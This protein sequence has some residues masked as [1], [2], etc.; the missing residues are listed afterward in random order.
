MSSEQSLLDARLIKTTL[1]APPPRDWAGSTPRDWFY[2]S[3]R[4]K[5]VPFEA[6]SAHADREFRE[7]STLPEGVYSYCDIKEKVNAWIRATSEEELAAVI[8]TTPPGLAADE[9][10]GISY[11]FTPWQRLYMAWQFKLPFDIYAHAK[12]DIPQLHEMARYRA[13]ESKRQIPIEAMFTLSKGCA[14]D[15]VFVT[16]PTACGKTALV[17]GGAYMIVSADNWDSLIEE[18]TMKKRGVLLASR[19]GNLM[20]AR[21]IIVAAGGN[22]F[23]HFATTVRRLKPRLHGVHVH[24]WEGT[25]KRFSVGDALLLDAIVFWVVPMKKLNE[26]LR[27]H[28][29]IAVA[30]CIQDE[31]VADTCKERTPTA[32]SPI[33]KKIVAQATPHALVDATR[34]RSSW[35]QDFFEGY[36]QRPSEVASFMEFRQF[37][38][39]TMTLRQAMKMELSSGT[40]F[41]EWVRR[42]LQSLMPQGMM[43]HTI[44]SKMC[45]VAAHLHRL[46]TE[47]VPANLFYVICHHIRSFFMSDE[48]REALRV[49]LEGSVVRPEQVNQFMTTITSKFPDRSDRSS[50][51]RLIQRMEEFTS[52]CPI[53]FESPSSGMRLYGCCGYCVCEGCATRAGLLQRCPFCRGNVPRQLPRSE[54]GETQPPPISLPEPEDLV[55]PPVLQGLSLE[56]ELCNCTS[57]RYRILDNLRR[58]LFVLRAHQYKRILLIIETPDATNGQDLHLHFNADD[59][60]RETSIRI[61]RV[62]DSMSGQGTR[63]ARIKQMFDSPDPAPMAL[64]SEGVDPRVLIGTDLAFA[65]AVVTVGKVKADIL[66]QAIGRIFRPLPTRDNTRP[67]QF[68]KIFS[69]R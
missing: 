11:N 21:L 45:T 32:K 14:P 25:S 47:M 52:S 23:A 40:A 19:P 49:L 3:S 36:L 53:C 61:V 31:L 8:D 67:V 16:L 50:L 4:A 18:Y 65:D 35:I 28:P 51:D 57:L 13:G 42:D 34:G 43:V 37:S 22:T 2:P 1:N 69:S 59:L 17:C 41:R 68:V 54:T 55:A 38:M 66:T 63:F 60:A 48:S 56:D 44:K 7:W 30:V 20:I 15:V 33:L 9:N 46:E 26:V 62:D 29:H 58:A 24:V 39:A 10:T 6:I 5:T 64:L 27:T 12:I